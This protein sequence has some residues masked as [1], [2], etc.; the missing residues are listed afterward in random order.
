MKDVNVRR[1]N[2]LQGLDIN[3]G[4]FLNNLFKSFRAD[5]DPALTADVRGKN[6]CWFCWE[7]RQPAL[8][9]QVKAVLTGGRFFVPTCGHLLTVACSKLK[10]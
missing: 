9:R 6:A 2:L 1:Y 5:L 7:K 3:R 8:G 10:C 4:T